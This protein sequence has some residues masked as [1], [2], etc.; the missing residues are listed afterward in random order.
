MSLGRMP[1]V[2]IVT[3]SFNQARFLRRTID[4]VL[5]QDY[6]HI[7]FLIIDGGSTDG[8]VDV[9]R[10]YG[11][12]VDWVSESDRG[13][14]D[15]INKGFARSRGD[16]GA[17]LNSDD[18]L[19]PGA[20]RAAVQ[21][22]EQHADW[23]MIYGSAFNI[24]ADD[25][26]IGRY[27]TAPFDFA[28]L[29]QNCFICQPAAFWR[30]DI[31]RRVG[32]FEA[33]LHFAMDLDYWL[34]IARAGGRIVH[35]PEVL[36]SSRVHPATKTLS[37]RQ[38]VYREILQVCRR[39]ASQA[40]FSQYYAYWHHRCHQAAHG[41]PRWLRRL[42]QPEYWLALGHSRWDR[43]EGRPIALAA[44]LIAALARRVGKRRVSGRAAAPPG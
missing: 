33:D 37:R 19:A 5:T 23:D 36:A 20:I 18:V 44:G 26:V 38:D 7:Q 39:H 42:P 31:A 10:S 28:Q 34:R 2:S 24:D 8:S 21:H 12:R 32:E 4:S 11:E 43:H 16:I 6:P 30:T 35:V 1:L 3:P 15:A 40:G 41:W 17:Y 25:R 9:L 27:E 29:L 22:F 13:Q 14:S